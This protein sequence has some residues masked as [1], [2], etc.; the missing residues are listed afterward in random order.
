M[1]FHDTKMGQAFYQSQLPRLIAAVEKLTSA[2]KAST[3]VYQMAQ[4]VPEDFLTDLY[5]GR[6]DPSGL[7]NSA[8]VEEYTLKI[9]AFQEQ[10]REV[11][12][13]EV[14]DLIEQYRTL[15]D[16]RGIH[17]RGQAFTA[18]FQSAMTMVAAGLAQGKTEEN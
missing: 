2:L 4:A 14:W 16:C 15:L 3:P 8:S 1:D 11:V 13:P 12:T 6:Y 7:P 17:E 5:Y 10:L 9:I 18:G